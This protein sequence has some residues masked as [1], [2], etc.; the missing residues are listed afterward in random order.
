MEE[1]L[2]LRRLVE[3]EG[4]TCALFKGGRIYKSAERGVKPLLDFIAGGTD[5]TGAY[6]ADKIV[7]KAAALLYSY[8]KIRRLYA[9][10]LGESALTVLRKHGVETEYG[11]L[12]RGIVNRAGTGICPMEEAVLQIEDPAEALAAVK[13]RAAFLSRKK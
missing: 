12:T 5:F 11:L 1:M 4:C 3:N 6:A 8:M 13:E 10:V 9:S 7:G 2:I